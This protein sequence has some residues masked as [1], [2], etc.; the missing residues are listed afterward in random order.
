MDFHAV[1]QLIALIG[2]VHLRIPLPFFVLVAPPR[3]ACGLGNG[4]AGRHDPSVIYDR[5]LPYRH[6][7]FADVGFDALIDEVFCEAV[8][9]LALERIA[10]CA[11]VSQ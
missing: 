6:A 9:L 8:D 1:V 11:E 4:G 5:A 7:P 2:L 10:R 3:S